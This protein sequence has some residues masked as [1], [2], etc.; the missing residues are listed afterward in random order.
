MTISSPREAPTGP[1]LGHPDD[2]VRVVRR[3]RS[4]QPTRFAHLRSLDGLRGLA[5][6]LVVLS[7]FA[8]GLA[9]GGFLGVDLFFVL[10]GFLI[11]S[12][13]VSELESTRRISLGNFWARRAR[14]LFPALL[15]VVFVVV[16]ATWVT[17]A[18]DRTHRVSA[19]GLASLLYVANWRFILSGESYIR[20]FI[21]TAPS[22]LRH[23]WSLAIEEQFYIVWPLVVTGVAALARR[24]GLIGRAQFRRLLTGCCIALAVVSVTWLVVQHRDGAGLDRLYYGTDS[25]MFIIL[26][27]A[28]LGAATAGSPTLPR[29]SR[30]R[31]MLMA[32]GWAA[33][34]FLLAAT[35]LVTTEQRWLYAGGF[36]VVALLLV[37]MLAA[38]AQPGPNP[39]ARFLEAKPLVGLG[40]ISYGVYLWHWPI[41]VWVTEDST[42]LSGPSLFAVRSAL[43]LGVSL[44]SYRFVERPIRQGWL[45]R[46]GAVG[47]RFTTALAV[48]GVLV[49]VAIPVAVYDGVVEQVDDTPVGEES[50]AA[51]SAY[52][53]A[54]RCDGPL[55]DEPSGATSGSR[56]R[57]RATR[58]PA[59]S[60]R[61]SPRSSRAGAPK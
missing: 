36:G 33:L 28:A 13:L 61:A 4:A 14:R 6:V 51:T 43:T 24:I 49:T 60:H 38:A 32:G 46:V 20:Q 53:Q 18:T 58:W 50:L 59:R 5:V 30:A 8:P 26:V 3:R 48:V 21:D 23:T 29:H 34:A 9:P 2:A 39:L 22:P 42:G 25:R 44:L 56:C 7:H 27:G 19:D 12:L 40:L 17:A 52:E 16:V 54:L 31:P 57:S 15:L 45:P 55:P 10:S 11:T 47:P 1:D 35:V 37:V 41:T